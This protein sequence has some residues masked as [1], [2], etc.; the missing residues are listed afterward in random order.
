MAR[1]ALSAA[2]AAALFVAPAGASAGGY[3]S[4]GVGDGAELD[5][6][7]A[8][9]FSTDPQTDDYR[10]AL[11][12][13]VGPI[14]IEAAVYGSELRGGAGDAAIVSAA[15]DLRAYHG[16]GAGFELFARGGVN[17][18]WLRPGGDAP[19]LAGRGHQLGFGA[20][21]RLTTGLIGEAALW[22]D[23]SRTY[24]DLIDGDAVAEV[25]GSYDLVQIGVSVGL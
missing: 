4:V 1:L 25:T 17:K 6:D 12:Q 13:R 3:V 21:Y 10:L 7:L 18:T 16:L 23:V 5:G 20:Q 14:A 19:D 15:V 24:V 2:A 9:G 11:G 8:A 22:L